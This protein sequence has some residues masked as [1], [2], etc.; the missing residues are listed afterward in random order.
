MAETL[1]IDNTVDNTVLTEEEQDSLQV[2]EALVEEQDQLLAGKY[3][4][5][6]ELEKAYIELQKK[7]GESDEEEVEEGEAEY[8][9]ESEETE[10]VEL[11]DNAELIAEA[12]AEF[13]DDGQLSE[14]TL[15]KFQGMSS[16]D[17]VNAYVEMS[18]F[19]GEDGEVEAAPDLSD[20]DINTVKNVVG[21][22]Q[23]YENIM[24]WSQNNLPESKINAFDEL[25]ESGSVE[26]ISLAVEGLKARYEMANGYEGEL[27]TGRAPVQQSD[28]FR[29]QAEL[30]AAMSDPRY[31]ND[32]AYRNDVIDKL[33]RSNVEF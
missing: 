22:E 4:N 11:S 1:T 20:T 18:E 23:A 33:D 6:Q 13:E 2:G 12:S 14:E 3:E 15:A 28:G 27:V 21:G 17:L 26:A 30:V 25:V 29:S 31:D 32:P 9:E 5:A 19:V 10:E 8:E 24:T 7:L 16:T